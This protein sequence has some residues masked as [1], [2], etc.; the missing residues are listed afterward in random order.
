MKS[1]AS[2]L[3]YVAAAFLLLGGCAVAWSYRGAF[4]QWLKVS[5]QAPT[6]LVSGNIDAHQSVLGFKTV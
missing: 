6:I 2:R 5:D 1:H 4:V 3:T